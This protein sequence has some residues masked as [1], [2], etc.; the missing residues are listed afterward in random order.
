M[1]QVL[2]AFQSGDV[3]AHEQG[4]VL[5]R[6]APSL[7]LAA[8]EIGLGEPAEPQKIHELGSGGQ[9][10]LGRREGMQA[11]Q[12][13]SSLQGIPAE[14]IDVEPSASGDEDLLSAWPSI[15]QTLEVVPPA[16]VLVDLVED[17]E[18]ARRQLALEDALAVLRDVPVQPRSL[19]SRQTQGQGGFS[20][21]ARSGQE[22]HLASEVLPDLGRKV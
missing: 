18:P 14:A 22:D 17:P 6:P 16:P 15:V 21:L 11:E 5:A 12:V 20:D 9:A 3:L 4:P 7:R 1:S 10:E 13:I 2:N 19:G 8:A